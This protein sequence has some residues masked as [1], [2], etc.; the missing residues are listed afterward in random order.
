MLDELSLLLL[1]AIAAGAVSAQTNLASST[2]WSNAGSNSVMPALPSAAEHGAAL[3]ERVEAMRAVCIENRRRICGKIIKVLPDGLVV[4]SGYTNLMRAPLNGS[5]LI[6]GTAE[7]ARA[8]NVVEEK[9]PDAICVGLVFLTDLPK[10]AG[11][12]PKVFDYVNLKA[13]L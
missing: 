4:D 13:F 7:A 10:N 5:W 2:N 11:D 3:A 6:P 9:K 1:F 12:K 8:T